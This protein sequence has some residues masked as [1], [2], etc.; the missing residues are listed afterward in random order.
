MALRARKVFGAFEK[1]APG[2]NSLLYMKGRLEW[3][4]F[5]QARTSGY[6]ETQIW[7]MRRQNAPLLGRLALLHFSIRAVFARSGGGF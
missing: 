7:C 6:I 4:G 1:R 2:H 3:R 5:V